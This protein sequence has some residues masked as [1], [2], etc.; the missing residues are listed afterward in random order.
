MFLQREKQ[1][2]HSPL[3]QISRARNHSLH[4]LCCQVCHIL[5]REGREA[6]NRFEGLYR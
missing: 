6:S 4:H 3:L 2:I 5:W 1:D